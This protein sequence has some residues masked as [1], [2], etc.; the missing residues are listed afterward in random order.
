MKYGFLMFVGL[1]LV[2]C[3]ALS[4]YTCGMEAYANPIK[5]PVHKRAQLPPI[6]AV[7]WAARPVV[8]T[9]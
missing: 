2:A 6:P 5:W 8:K 1:L 3:C 7:K 4:V 9:L